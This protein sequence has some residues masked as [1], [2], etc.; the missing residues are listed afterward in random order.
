MKPGIS[1]PKRLYFFSC[2]CYETALSAH[3]ATHYG[4]NRVHFCFEIHPRRFSLHISKIPHDSSSTKNHV[5]PAD[6]SKHFILLDR[7]RTAWQFKSS[8]YGSQWLLIATDPSVCFCT[9]PS[10]LEKGKKKG[11]KKRAGGSG[12]KQDNFFLKCVWEREREGGREIGG[13]FKLPFFF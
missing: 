9:F 6:G 10:S 13:Y 1:S 2:S 12:A 7:F 3:L 8:L 4:Q 11:R 5:N